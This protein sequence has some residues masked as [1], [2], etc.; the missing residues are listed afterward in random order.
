[1]PM[2]RG[3]L[4]HEYHRWF[5]NP[6]PM[7]LQAIDWL[8]EFS[9]DGCDD[10]EA[11]R[12]QRAFNPAYEMGLNRIRH[13][14]ELID[15]L[16]AMVREV[17]RRSVVELRRHFDPFEQLQTDGDGASF[18]VSWYLW[19]YLVVLRIRLRRLLGDQRESPSPLPNPAPL[20]PPLPTTL[21]CAKVLPFSR[22][23]DDDAAPE[24]EPQRVEPFL[25]R[26]T[27]P[28]DGYYA[29]AH[30]RAL[31][32]HVLKLRGYRC[33]LCILHEGPIEIHHSNYANL[34]HEDPWL[35]VIPLCD[36]C[37]ARFHHR[38]LRNRAAKLP[39]AA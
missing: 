12:K 28:P 23:D 16:D 11:A 2:M 8:D 3:W 4:D 10:A 30:W 37:H 38:L 29:S 31:R 35:D 21:A 1:M 6:D 13:T 27:F 9:S 15:E 25:V 5:P 22:D 17:E 14:Q 19:Q 32:A 33:A 34:W 18:T 24:P 20:P 7:V 39:K 26:P 36:E